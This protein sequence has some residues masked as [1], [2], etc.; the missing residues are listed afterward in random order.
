MFI[1]RSTAKDSPRSSG[2]KHKSVS[3][4]MWETMRSARARVIVSCVAANQMWTKGDRERLVQM[5]MHGDSAASQRG[6]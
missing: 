1:E 4:P 5:F 3:R 2:A 6:S